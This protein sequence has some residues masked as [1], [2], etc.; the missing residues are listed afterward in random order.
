MEDRQ[1]LD[2]A[3]RLDVILELKESELVQLISELCKFYGEKYIVSKE[4]GKITGK[5]HYH[6]YIQT[7]KIKLDSFKKQVNRKLPWYNCNKA[8]KSVVKVKNLEKY[9][10]YICKDK[11]IIMKRSF[12]QEDL[13]E[14]AKNW[15][16]DKVYR[17]HQGRK[18]IDRITEFMRENNFN[19]EIA[20]LRDISKLVLT[21]YKE[22]RLVM[23][24]YRMRNICQTLYYYGNPREV[25]NDFFNFIQKQM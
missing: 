6:G 25:E 2:I 9:L 14:Y 24:W 13:V 15:I 22:K 3:F 1:T 21:Y 5:I 4:S 17:E 18:V 16:P 8:T 23:D 11:N 20:D 19:L 10:S 7:N 12:T